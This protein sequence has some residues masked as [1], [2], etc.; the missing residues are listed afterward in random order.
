MKK[1]LWVLLTALLMT[2]CSSQNVPEA[3]ISRR[4]RKALP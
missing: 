1:I 4:P 3:E 2:G